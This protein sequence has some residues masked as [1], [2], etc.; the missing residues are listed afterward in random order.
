MVE[1]CAL[2]LLKLLSSGLRVGFVTGP[3]ALIERIELHAQASVLHSS[4]IAQAL[5][6]VYSTH[7]AMQRRVKATNGLCNI[8]TALQN[9]IKRRDTF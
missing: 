2:I 6:Q 7:G 9:F 8:V 3:P 1:S 4:G 5:L